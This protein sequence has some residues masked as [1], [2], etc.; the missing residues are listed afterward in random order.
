VNA[1]DGATTA[2]VNAGKRTLAV[3]R[4]G[5]VALYVH[6]A[7]RFVDLLDCFREALAEVHQTESGEP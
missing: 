5:D 6:S 3:F 7:S 1:A 4:T 2:F